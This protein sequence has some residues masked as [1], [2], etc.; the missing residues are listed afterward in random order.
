MEL[1]RKTLPS[2]WDYGHRYRVRWFVG[3]TE[4]DTD[5]AELEQFA[6]K[7]FGP[8]TVWRIMCLAGRP[9][10]YHSKQLARKARAELKAF[11]VEYFGLN[12]GEK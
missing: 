7:F 3:L 5:G 1:Y 4:R 8:A 11:F 2:G 12:R 9:R 6:R 10:G